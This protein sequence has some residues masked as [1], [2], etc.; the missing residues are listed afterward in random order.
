[1]RLSPLSGAMVSAFL[2]ALIASVPLLLEW[3]VS[4]AGYIN[5]MIAWGVISICNA[6]E[7]HARQR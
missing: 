3:E 2:V 4:S 6:I 1:M 5:M 7:W